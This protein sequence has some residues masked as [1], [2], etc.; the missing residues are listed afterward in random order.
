MIK[1]HLIVIYDSIFN[2]VFQG[3]VVQP[4]IKHLSEQPE[5]RAIIISFERNKSSDTSIAQFVTH[6][7]I[8]LIICR[9]LPFIGTASL[10]YASWQLNRMVKNY[11][12]TNIIARGPLAGWIVAHTHRAAKQIPCIVQARGLAACEYRYAHAN[13]KSILS[14]FF[15][16]LRCAQYKS[17]E[18][19]VYG[20]YAQQTNVQIKTVSNA[21]T[22]YIIEKFGTP[23]SKVSVEKS[24]I[25]QPFALAKINQWRS[26]IR[27]ELGIDQ[28]AYVYVYNGSAKPWQCP[29]QTVQ[30]FCT[31]HK[32][33][34]SSFLLV[35]TQDIAK[36]Q[37]LLSQY[38]VAPNSYRVRHVLHE[39]I[40]QYLAAA[41]AGVM[42]R[43]KHIINW[44]SRPTKVLEYQTVGLKIVHNNTVSM[45]V[46]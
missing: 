26:A 18:R 37:T 4:L 39:Q 30:F 10:W 11:R 33:N 21:L 9:Q 1:T 35:L 23:A 25:P 24:D 14:R 34:P 20:T 16:A 45:L 13:K 43:E 22:Q 28:Q 7:Q 3:Q 17:I 41:D 19:Y 5:D 27:T 2:S 6:P 38:N 15:H 32:K 29:E 36:F 46:E 8:T 40:Y 12:P 31:Q 44:V 42:F